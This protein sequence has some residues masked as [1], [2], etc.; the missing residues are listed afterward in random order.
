MKKIKILM[1][2][3]IFFILNSIFINSYSQE[4]TYVFCSDNRDNWKW[5]LDANGNYIIIKGKWERFHVEG[6]F[7]TYFI[8]DDPLNKIFYLSRKC[9]ND[10]GI[11]YETPYPANNITS[12]WSLFALNN[13][14]FYQG[15]IA[16]DYKIGR[17]TYTKLFRIHS[18]YYNNK[19]SIENFNKSFITLNSILNR[20]KINFLLKDG[21]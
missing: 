2:C 8:P 20:I 3:M 11:H 12:R 18:D 6:I 17:S 19:Y 14:H 21:A 4:Y 15:K 1:S 13:N 7:F 5:L 16:I 9:V 10:F